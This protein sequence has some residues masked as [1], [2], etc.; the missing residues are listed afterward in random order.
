MASLAFAF[1]RLADLP[2]QLVVGREYEYLSWFFNN[3]HRKTAITDADARSYAAA[4]AKPSA[5]RA[6]FEYYRAFDQDAIENAGDRTPLAMPVLALG[7]EHSP[8]R[9]YLHEQ[10]RGEALR[11]QGDVVPDCGHFIAEEQPIW[12]V[13]RIREFLSE[14][15]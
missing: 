8:W 15:N 9:T 11:L 3:A 12:L 13:D 14:P 4:Y 5:L 6:G 1:H 7:G 10:L 2:E